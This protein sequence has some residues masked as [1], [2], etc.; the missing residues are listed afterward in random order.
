M[1]EIT[2]ELPGHIPDPRAEPVRETWSAGGK[3][4]LITLQ[5]EE[6]E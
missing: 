1:K 4:R 3:A 5:N 6:T 2:Q